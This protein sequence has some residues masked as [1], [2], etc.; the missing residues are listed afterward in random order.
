MRSG[1]HPPAAPTG[2]LGGFGRTA[3]SSE[4]K[5]TQKGLR[6]RSTKII[7]V[8]DSVLEVLSAGRPHSVKVFIEN[9]LVE[10]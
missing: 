4:R 2:P 7:G 1:G 10:C 8:C 6:A 9:L 5:T 3:G